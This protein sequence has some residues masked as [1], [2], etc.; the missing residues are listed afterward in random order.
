MAVVFGRVPTNATPDP[1]NVRVMV[2]KLA[3]DNQ[4]VAT[5]GVQSSTVPQITLAQTARASGL[6]PTIVRAE[7]NNARETA[8]TKLVANSLMAVM[9]GARRLIVLPVTPALMVRA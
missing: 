9:A 1:N 8:L 7:A 2:T 4:T 3:P 6:A 5:A